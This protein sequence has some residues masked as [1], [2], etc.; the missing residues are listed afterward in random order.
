MG[1]GYLENEILDRE[2]FSLVGLGFKWTLFDGGQAG[3]RA[4]AL[5]SASR[6]AQFRR[7]DLRSLVELEVRQAW[8]DV[9]A[10]R[11]RVEASHESVA[12]AGENLRIAR[13]LYRGELGTN[14]QVLEAVALEIA[15]VN[16]RDD[17]VLDEALALV[18]LA[19]TVGAL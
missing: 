8:L 4:A 15:A 6:A 7:E 18:E 17:A 1:Y 2:R 9:Q 11:A 16:G 10:A 13:E 5:R 3:G 19:R 14:T 12:Q